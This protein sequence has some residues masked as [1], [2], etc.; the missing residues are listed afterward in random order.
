MKEV[1]GLDGLENY[2]P[3][4]KFCILW[5]GCAEC[6]EPFFFYLNAHFILS[7]NEMMVYS[8]TSVCIYYNK[9]GLNKCPL[10]CPVT[11]MVMTMPRSKGGDGGGHPHQTLKII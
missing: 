5:T 4:L 1:R 3:L 11:C 8:S 10:F 6:V 9:K 2:Y 7:K